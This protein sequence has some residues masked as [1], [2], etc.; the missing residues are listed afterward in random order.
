MSTE[1]QDP[2]VQKFELQNFAAS[3]NLIIHDFIEVILSSRQSLKKRRI[4]ELKEKLKPGDTLI[5]TELSRLGRGSL[6]ILNTAQYL[7]DKNIKIITTKNGQEYSSDNKQGQF[8][9]TIF[10]AVCELER[11]AISE[12]TKEALA[13][14]KA[15]GIKLGRPSGSRGKSK[16]DQY[17]EQMLFLRKKY[18]LNSTQICMALKIKKTGGFSKYFSERVLKA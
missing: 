6:E 4:D 18:K 9:L 2:R 16:Y 12:R 10:A 15:S 13:F 8:F 17:L 7:M 11:E 3:R 14:K 5:I 1:T